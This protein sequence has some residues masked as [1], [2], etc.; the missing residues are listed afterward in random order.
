M[1]PKGIVKLFYY[2]SKLRH[3]PWYFWD[4]Y[5]LKCLRFMNFKTPKYIVFVLKPSKYKSWNGKHIITVK[6]SCPQNLDDSQ[7]EEHISF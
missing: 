1:I 6:P 2:L 3:I 5:K 7:L 4:A